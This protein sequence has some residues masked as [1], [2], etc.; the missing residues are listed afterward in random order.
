MAENGVQILR[1]LAISVAVL[2]SLLA[3]TP[4]A[5][6]PVATSDESYAVLDRVFPDPLAGCQNAQSDEPCSP[7][8]QGNFPAE[9]FIQFGEFQRALEYMNQRSEWARYMEVWPLDDGQFPGN[10]LG[11]LEFDP[12]PAYRSAGLPTADLSRKKSDLYVVRVTDETVPDAGKKRYTLSL[13]IHGIERAGAEGGTRAMEDLVTA[14]TTGKA[15]DAIVHPSV[16]P[17]SPTFDDVLKKSIIYFTYPNPDG[18]RRGSITDA[19]DQEDLLFAGGGFFFQ[20]YNGNGVD[21]NRDWPD[22]GYSFRPYSGLSE[23]E[24]R[25][26]AAFYRDAEQ[27]GGQFDAGDDLHGQPFA[28]ALSYTMLPHGRHDWG[29]DQRIRDAAQRIHLSSEAS[30]TWSPLIQQ[31]GQPRGGATDCVEGPVG[32]ICQQMYGQT[33][34]TV[35]DTINYTTTG[36][37]GDWFDSNAGLGADGIDNE[38]SFSHIDR[39]I[40]FDPHGEQLH[41]DGNKALIYAHIDNL[42]HPP[43][44]RSFDAGGRKGYVASPRLT[45]DETVNQPD[46]SGQPQAPIEMGPKPQTGERTVYDEADGFVVNQVNGGMRVQV[47]TANVQGVGTTYPVADQVRLR[48]ECKCEDHHGHQGP[49]D[50]TEPEWTVVAEDF[51]QQQAY[52]ASGLV[53]TVNNPQPNVPWR[54]VIEGDNTVLFPAGDPDQPTFYGGTKAGV[55]FTRGPASADGNTGGDDPPRLAAYDVANTDFFNDLNRFEEPGEGFGE[56]TPDQVIDGSQNL[57]ELDTLVLADGALPGFTGRFGASEL[58]PPNDTIP[59][60]STGPTVPAAHQPD[61]DRDLSDPRARVPGSYETVEFEVG[62]PPDRANKSMTAEITATGGD[63]DMYLYRVGEDGTE[64]YLQHSGTDG[65]HEVITIGSPKPGSYRLYIDNW[66]AGPDTTWEGEVR[67]EGYPADGGG[68]D[69]GAYTAEEKD[70]WIAKLTD[71]VEGGG[72]LVLTDSSLLALPDLV[73]GLSRLDVAQ[74]TVYVGQ[75]SFSDGEA[76]TTGDPLARDVA[77]PGARFGSGMRRQTFEPTPLGFA[78]QNAEGD[79]S[80]HSPQYDVDR[81]AWEGVGGRYVAGSITSSP[82]AAAAVTDRVTIGEVELGEGTIRIAGALL[83]QPSTAYDHPLGIEP[84]AVTYT[85]YTL[86]RNLFDHS[87]PNRVDPPGEGTVPGPVTSPGGSAGGN[88]AS[89]VKGKAKKRCA[90]KGKAK[91]RKGCKKKGKR[92][93]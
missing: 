81:G 10:D 22:I 8:A 77:A 74:Q 2:A 84:Y 42:L 86:A 64:T 92:R 30:L 70:R 23:P 45:R 68:G 14:H 60:A 71:F 78:I 41:V 65:G 82:T 1:G 54:I 27:H 63:Y 38:M 44:D 7:N 53:A 34:G 17:D 61:T 33:W 9:Q 67:F 28:D 29:K 6:T 15:D 89:S 62:G 18:W 73:P 51:N 69:T 40:V 13:S 5:A 20:R 24:T 72:N 3:A 31:S 19:V 57:A 93:G 32:A 52:L 37:L 36:T 55:E 90:K 79:G 76:E 83:P 66:L 58:P 47:T 35:F 46:D 80:S 50:R 11:R 12:D 4:A 88:D 26:F 43:A 48:V 75:V 49:E 39:N 21:P 16:D 85:G 91:R 56:V 25:A 87:N 59:I